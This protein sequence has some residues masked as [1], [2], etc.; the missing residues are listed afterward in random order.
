MRIFAG[1]V[2]TRDF[3]LVAFNGR[4][5]DEVRPR[6]SFAVNKS[7]GGAQAV[8]TDFGKTIVGLEKE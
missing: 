5:V 6:N 1:V 7:G 8:V 4:I 3:E 2:A